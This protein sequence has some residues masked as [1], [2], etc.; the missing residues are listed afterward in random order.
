[1]QI[2][3]FSAL[4]SSCDTDR[5]GPIHKM[6]NV[7]RSRQGLSL[8][9]LMTVTVIIGILAAMSVPLYERI[10]RV[11]LRANC[12]SNMRSL[13]VAAA[14]H[15]TEHKTWPQI[16]TTD[17]REP[18]FAI[19]WADAL[20]PYGL[21]RIGWV[22]PSIQ[23][24]SGNPDLEDDETFRLDYLPSPFRKGQFEP[25]RYDRHPW[26][27]ERGD[28]HGNGNLI[29]FADGSI[30]ALKEIFDDKNKAQTTKQQFEDEFGEQ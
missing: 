13:H 3:A 21:T 20:V 30:L 18:A 10:E 5:C 26:F 15:I 23:K 2:T 27:S 25:Y 17:S 9:E 4:N 16:S 12:M 28:V 1:M 14:S 8:M 22:C 29:I 19:E 6:L 7:R 11:M 24:E